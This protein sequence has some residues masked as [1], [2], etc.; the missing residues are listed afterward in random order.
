[1]KSKNIRIKALIK[2]AA[3]RLTKIHFSAFRMTTPT[4]LNIRTAK[5][6]GII[7]A[8]IKPRSTVLFS[9]TKMGL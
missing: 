8:L 2:M 9:W 5:Q 4:L 3:K 6:I 1:M 7:I